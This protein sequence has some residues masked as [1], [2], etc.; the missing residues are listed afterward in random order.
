VLH[1]EELVGAATLACHMR[2]GESAERTVHL[3]IRPVRLAQ[4]K[5]GWVCHE[6][7]PHVPVSRQI[8]RG[9]CP[10]WGDFCCR[11]ISDQTVSKG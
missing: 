5:H 3:L 6:S 1:A 7:D 8:F 10:G 2:L 9:S 11:L 4:D